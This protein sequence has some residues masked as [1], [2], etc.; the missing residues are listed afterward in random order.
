MGTLSSHS[1]CPGSGAAL[2]PGLGEGTLIVEGDHL[3]EAGE[4]D[5]KGPPVGSETSA[6]HEDHGLS[7][8]G[9][10]G[11]SS[12]GQH[13]DGEGAHLRKCG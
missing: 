7:R 13:W 3:P 1:W 11:D 8:A 10:R 5:T 2:E 4:A 12:P 9:V 6:L